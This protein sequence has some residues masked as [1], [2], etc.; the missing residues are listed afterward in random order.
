MKRPSRRDLMFLP[1]QLLGLAVPF[2]PFDRT[3]VAVP[4]F[5]EG[6]PGDVLDW[7]GFQ[8]LI[9]VPL[10]LGFAMAASTVRQ[11]ARGTLSRSERI[12]AYAVAFAVLGWPAVRAIDP[13]L[14]LGN[15]FLRAP[16]C[17]IA[18]FA[19]TRKGGLPDHVHAHIALLA[20]W[21]LNM[22]FSVIATLAHPTPIGPGC[23]A[24]AASVLAV[25][26]E[27]VLRARKALSE[28]RGR[29]GS[30]GAMTVKKPT[31]REV[32][33]IAGGTAG[34]AVIFLPFVDG[35][36]PASFLTGSES[37][38]GQ[39]VVLALV[40]AVSVPVLASTVRQAVFGPL[41][42]WEVRAAYGLALAAFGATALVILDLVSGRGMVER[43]TAII[44]PSVLV[45]AVGAA[46]ILAATRK[47]RVPPGIHAHVAML[48]AWMPNAAYCLFE[49][50]RDM[51]WGAG[52]YLA[53]VTFIAYA[54]EAGV[55]VRRA[56]RSEGDP[57]EGAR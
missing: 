48:V 24:A 31:P 9:L 33:F 54:G 36:T 50:G 30:R 29:D 22:G 14:G 6:C 49:L 34:V 53:I 16:V 32:A 40:A 21:I 1:G 7:D 43:A 12:A 55:R 46:I 47:G 19:V 2:L 41:S 18:I 15:V 4:V 56:L 42:K 5:F 51:R 38:P 28:A 27:A 13:M 52:F 20:A 23:W 10:V 35:Y 25:T 26:V 57:Q 45:L 8:Q 39:A 17:A 11:A 3:Y 44:S 37:Y